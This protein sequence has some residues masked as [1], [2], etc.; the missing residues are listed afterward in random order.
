MLHT[1]QALLIRSED[2]CCEENVMHQCQI[3]YTTSNLTAKEQIYETHFSLPEM[4]ELVNHDGY[5]NVETQKSD[6]YEEG[7]VKHCSKGH[8]LKIR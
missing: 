8:S 6:Y 3:T 2:C 1:R 7:E 4:L 5:Y